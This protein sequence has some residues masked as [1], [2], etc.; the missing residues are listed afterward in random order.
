MEIEI[1]NEENF[2]LN[3]VDNN[4]IYGKVYPTDSELEFNPTTKHGIRVLQNGIEQNNALILGFSGAT[5]IYENSYFI[6]NGVIFICCSNE[7]YSLKLEDLSLNWK[8]EFDIATCFGIY[9]FEGDFVTH[10]EL[11]VNRIDKNGN[12]KW[13]FGARDIFVNPDGK[14]EIKIIKNRIKLIDW[15]GYKYELN[16]DGKLLSEMKTT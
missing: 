7:I 1:I 8:S 5:G 14:T 13:T 16:A 11:Q 9:E 6:K 4:R 12:I 10:G 3:S 2:D 15:Q